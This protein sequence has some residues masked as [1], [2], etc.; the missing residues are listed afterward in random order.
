MKTFKEFLTEEITV[1]D[2]KRRYQ[3]FNL[4][5]FHGELPDIP[6][7]FKSLKGAFARVKATRNR[8]TGKITP[9][10][11]QVSN[12]LRITRK[13]LDQAL[14][15]EMIHVKLF[16]EQSN[17]HWRDG[18]GPEFEKLRKDL[19][20]KV[21]MDIPR[22]ESA[23]EMEVFDDKNKKELFVVLYDVGYVSLFT[24]KSTQ[25][26]ID[27]LK[28]SGKL[29]TRISNVIVS[30]GKQAGAK[31][32]HVGVVETVLF[33]KYKVQRSLRTISANKISKKDYEILKKEIKDFD[34][35]KKI[36]I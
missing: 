29:S 3:E 1:N 12:S 26:F 18:H 15:H 13:F 11:L 33:K 27:L 19:E 20:R 9:K 16:H 32:A 28:S 6:I 36:E 8:T 25:N 24:K 34:V 14:I 5:L 4:K 21:G 10:V 31:S 2:I 35:F 22:T 7:E 30:L 17:G 23:D